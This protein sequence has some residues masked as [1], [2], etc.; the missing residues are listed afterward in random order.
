M[1]GRTTAP[2]FGS[3]GASDPDERGRRLTPVHGESP[4]TGTARAIIRMVTRR[5]WLVA[6][7]VVVLLAEM[8]AAMVSTAV[9][10]TPTIDE[11]VYVGTA[12]VYVQ[13]HRPPVQRRASAARQADHRGR[14]RVRSSEARPG[15]HRQPERTRPAPA[16]RVGQRCR[17]ADA[18]RPAADDRADTAVRAGRL[19][20]R[21][22]PRGD[23]RRSGGARA[24][25]LLPDLIANGVAR[26]AGRARPP[27]SCSP[28]PGWLWRARRT[29]AGST[30]RWP[31]SRW[32]PRWPRR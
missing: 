13:Q 28:R 29:A 24:V 15:F 21:P 26:H 3:K 23:G 1:L 22:G 20:V 25:R 27:A 32:V 7:L 19:R 9:A 16:L 11:P 18:L 30:C 4:R 5:R 6:G 12:T 2:A 8:A 17:P 14:R 10:Q 31:A